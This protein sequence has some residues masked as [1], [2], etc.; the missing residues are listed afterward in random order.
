M[1]L[2]LRELYQEVILDHN[3]NP[4]NHKKIEDCSHHAD[5]D[6]PLCGDQISVYLNTDGN[7]IQD[8]S[9]EG[10]GC[11]ISVA[12][13][14]IMTDLIKGRSLDFVQKLF[15]YFQSLVTQED[16]PPDFT[17]KETSL[18][19][20]QVL[21]GVKQFPLRVKCATLAWQTLQAALANQESVATH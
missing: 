3:K 7:I 19:E 5:G 21:S 10:Q 16:T 6:N 9:F 18:D 12:S 8:I 17:D 11:A 14:S 20:L 15:N 2:D 1:D 4:H 13:A